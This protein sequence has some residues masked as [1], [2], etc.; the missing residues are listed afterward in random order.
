MRRGITEKADRILINGPKPMSRRDFM[1]QCARCAAG[2]GL[3][4]IPLTSVSSGAVELKKGAVGRKLSPYYTPMANLSVRCELCPHHCEV[5]DGD[6]GR[7]DVRENV[8][9]RF[10]SL[11]YGNPCAIQIDP[12]EKIPL[13]HV[14][15]GVKTYSLATA[16][17]NL[18][19]KFCQDWENARAR[20]EETYN[21][22]LSPQ[23]AVN[24]ALTFE[25]SAVA[26][27]FVEPVVFFEYMT[28]IGRKTKNRPLLNTL[29]SNGYVNEKPLANIAPYLDAACIDLKA[30]ND[31]IY[32]E[33]TGGRLQP[34]LDTLLRLREHRIHT[35]I[36][37][38]VIPGKNDDLEQIRAMSRWIRASLGSAVP[39][40]FIRFYPRYK[41]K[42]IP[43]TPMATLEAARTVAL[44]EGLLHVY[45]N[46]VP[47]HP[48][49]HTYCPECKHTLI[50]RVGYKTAVT[51]LQA[52][53]CRRCGQRIY[54][55]WRI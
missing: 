52:G 32:R 39:L 30:F 49:A 51:G 11:V 20:P 5:R 33:L 47:E 25:C 16:G 37:N 53:Q 14:L 9:G 55:I 42:S 22:L 3:M 6:R 40:H 17:C 28:D 29:H 13:Y 54:G 26:S 38:L 44:Q 8:G 43:P 21:Y 23:A 35:E 19:C 41:L 15:P 31:D 45:I 36:V 50:Q 10:Y 34:V 27:T 24:Q 1:Y 2:A 7:C 18:D 46:N 4:V 12:I 48:A